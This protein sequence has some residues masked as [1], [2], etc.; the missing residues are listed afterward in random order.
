MYLAVIFCGLYIVGF[1]SAQVGYAGGF[2]GT[3]VG[4]NPGFMQPFPNIIPPL[5][6]PQLPMPYFGPNIAS[7]QGVVTRFGDGAGGETIVSRFGD[8]VSG[9]GQTV[10]SRFGDGVSGGGV[11]TSSVSG[12]G[13]GAGQTLVSRFGDG[14]SGGGVSTSSVSGFGSG[15]GQTVVSRFGDGQ[16]TTYVSGPQGTH[17]YRT[18]PQYP[19]TQVYQNQPGQTV[20]NSRFN[21]DGSQT[22]SQTSTYVSPGGASQSSFSQTSNSGSFTPQSVNSRGAYADNNVQPIADNRGYAQTTGGAAHTNYQP[23]QSTSRFSGGSTHVASSG[24]SNYGSTSSFTSSS[25]V[26]GQGHHETISSVNNNGNV[27]T[28]RQSSGK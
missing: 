28:Y 2:A 22:V 12:F 17:T 6:I 7:G 18:S 21:D 9:G 1:T 3:G 25:N 20:V 11:S 14:V 4:F 15:T 5:M 16:S 27:Q 13:N 26:D 23:P 19:N 8:G 10:V 24:P